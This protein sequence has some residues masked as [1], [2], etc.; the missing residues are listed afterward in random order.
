MIGNL[1]KGLTV[2]IILIGAIFS[3]ISAIGLIRLPDLYTRAH[4]SSKSATLGVLFILLGTFLFF[5]I[6]EQHFSTKLLL[7]IFFVFLTAPVSAHMIC[8]CAYRSRV[9]L[10]ETSIRDDLADCM[11]VEQ[12]M[13]R[14]GN[15]V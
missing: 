13:S 14:E 9:K 8:R 10:T 4:A 5:I 12:G 6:E 7:G 11:C 3:F 2:V 15:D 1:I